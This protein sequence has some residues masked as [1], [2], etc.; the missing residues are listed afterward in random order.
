MRTGDHRARLALGALAIAVTTS[1]ASR[2]IAADKATCLGAYESAQTDRNA[3]KLRASRSKLLVCGKPE[4][5]ALLRADCATW[6][7]EVDRA[8]P[9]VIVVAR[10]RGKTLTDARLSVDDEPL[11]ETLIG[12]ALEVDPGPRV[13]RVESPGH[14]PAVVTVTI[15]EAEKNRVV[16]LELAPQSDPG[17]EP[18]R[19]P[20]T[21]YVLAGVGA[22]GLVSFSYFGL[23]GLDRRSDLA[24]C[25][26]KCAE[27]DVDAVR[28]DF[29]AADVSLAIA[30]LSFGGAAYLHFTAPGGGP[31]AV[32]L[33]IAPR[34]AGVQAA[35][36]LAF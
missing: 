1:W 10:A 30:L 22:L 2:T 25:K 7:V 18:A 5:P 29:V 9:T 23:R 17:P 14:A 4:C 11:A 28:S 32:G 35:L 33:S 8:L 12:A 13:F 15:R 20:V 19:T 34:K 21:S 36:Q 3:G 31:A 6:L 26:G 16:E 24:A 27:A